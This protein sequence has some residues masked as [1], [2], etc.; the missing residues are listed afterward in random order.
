V[1]EPEPLAINRFRYRFFATRFLAGCARLGLVIIRCHTEPHGITGAG[2][3][4]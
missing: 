1:A 3:G 2:F 4:P